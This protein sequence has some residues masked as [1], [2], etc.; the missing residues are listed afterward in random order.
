MLLL[1]FF[2]VDLI[3]FRFEHCVFRAHRV[4]VDAFVTAVRHV[5]FAVL[6]WQNSYVLRRVLLCRVAVLTRH[7]RDAVFDLVL[8]VGVPLI[9]FGLLA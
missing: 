1:V 3:F 7:N 2:F 8:Q 6:A 4:L 5:I 9:K